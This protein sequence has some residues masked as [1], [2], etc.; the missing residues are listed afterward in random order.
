MNADDNVEDRIESIGEYQADAVPEWVERTARHA[1][2][3]ESFLEP[4]NWKAVEAQNGIPTESFRQR[5]YDI[6]LDPTTLSPLPES[7]TSLLAPKVKSA[8]RLERLLWRCAGADAGILSRAA[9]APDR[10][11]Q[12]ATGAAVLLTAL[13][14]TLA[15]SFALPVLLPLPAAL[16]LALT[17]GLVTLN[18]D[19]FL[20]SSLRRDRHVH[21]REVLSAVSRLA[22][23]VIFA[24]TVAVPLEIQLFRAE[25]DRSRADRKLALTEQYHRWQLEAERLQA[26]ISARVTQ[27][28]VLIEDLVA[29][30]E[31]TRGNLSRGRGPIFYEKCGQLE[32]LNQQLTVLRAANE[33][34]IHDL[35]AKLAVAQPVMADVSYAESHPR[36][37]LRDL[38]ALQELRKDPTTGNIVGIT[39][40]LILLL[41]VIVEVMPANAALRHAFER[42]R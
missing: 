7:R 29:E 6:V 35:E 34:Q 40:L 31:G 13:V 5:C 14:A 27:Q 32:L 41:V 36:S 39:Q 33:K 1:R 12:A 20:V 8:R 30:A 19:R 28:T 2:G 16:V 22:I 21:F 18:L 26:D 25:I 4:A 42:L 17:W 11:V 3:F 10:M 37:L 24:V 9:T 15:A 38:L 23:A